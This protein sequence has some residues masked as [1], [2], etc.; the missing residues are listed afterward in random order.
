MKDRKTVWFSA[1]TNVVPSEYEKWLEDMEAQ[2][3][4]L[5][6]IGQWSSIRMVFRRGEPKKYRYVYDM[7]A[8]PKEDYV[9]TYQAFGWEV[10]G[11]MASAFLWRKPYQGE[12]PEAF[13][14]AESLARRGTRFA[15]AA[16][17]SM[18]MFWVLLAIM[19]IVLLFDI[20]KMNFDDRLSLGIFSI[21]IGFFA[22]YMTYVVRKIYKNREK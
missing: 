11:R 14:D 1:L 5:E 12:R 7:Q 18:V 21:L 9:P 13:T 19:I 3:W 17:V 22:A 16:S 10:V 2:G 6:K 15:G 4:H 20:G 8:F